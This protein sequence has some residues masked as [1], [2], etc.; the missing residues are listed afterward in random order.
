VNKF[1]RYIFKKLFTVTFFVLTVLICIFILVDFSEN[2]DDFVDKGATLSQ[3]WQ[4]YYLNYIPEM[5]RLVSPLAVLVACLFLT[6]QMTERLEIIALKSSGVSLYRLLAPYLVFGVFVGAMV[7]Y[8]DANIIPVSNSER[9]AFEQQYLSGSSDRIDRGGIFRQE[10]DS[11]VINIEFYDGNANIGYR[12]TYLEFNDEQI[13]KVITANRIT[14]VD[15]TSTWVMDRSV[16]REFDQIQ[17]REIEDQRQILPLNILPRDLS[18][19]SSD[20]YQLTYPQAL[21]YIES[22]KRIGAGGVTLPQVQ[23]FSRMAYPF[24]IVVVCLI[25][26]ALA[27]ERRKGGKGVYIASGLA[28]SFIYLSMMKVIEPFGIAGTVS[29]EFAAI[30][31][32]AFFLSLGLGMLIYAKK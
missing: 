18:R 29:P 13:Q 20:I 27:T 32:H 25:G 4:E 10:S 19:R 8:L 23:L 12:F 24:S 9:I 14:W 30:F 26:F 31:P 2:S 28:I 1:D 3:I 6:V 15:S 21:E 7:S 5:T 17:F 22:I 11:T 16:Q